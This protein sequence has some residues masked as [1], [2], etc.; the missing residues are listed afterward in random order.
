MATWRYVVKDI[1]KSFKQTFDDADIR[2]TQVLWWVITI[3]NAIRARQAMLVESGLH[4]STYSPVTVSKDA[5]G[6]KYFDLPV[7]IMDLPF[8]KGVEYITYNEDTGCCCEGATFAQ[9]LFQPT[10]PS[11]LHVLYRDEYTKPSPSNP[12]F[13]RVGHMVNGVQVNRVYLVG[14]ECIDITDIELAIKGV[15]DPSTVCD[16]DDPIPLADEHIIELM[17]EVLSLGRF[18]MM[19]P[20]ERE[21]EGSDMSDEKQVKPIPEVPQ[22]TE[23]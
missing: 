17:K 8:E 10:T 3:A 4:I 2:Q 15:I 20:E 14:T 22:Q 13:Y 12:Y 1:H 21:N 7:Q 23:Q 6:R 11:K 19:I 9:R 18:V 5:K 16:L